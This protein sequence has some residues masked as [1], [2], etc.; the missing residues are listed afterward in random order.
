MRGRTCVHIAVAHSGGQDVNESLPFRKQ[1]QRSLR[2]TAR[3]VPD[4]CY[5]RGRGFDGVCSEP[6]TES[7]QQILAGAPEQRIRDPSQ[8]FFG[9]LAAGP[10]KLGLHS[11]GTECMLDVVPKATC[12]LTGPS[13]RRFLRKVMR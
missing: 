6:R 10:V 7:R 11:I 4:L 8:E 3:P 13:R 9:E 12:L 5:E 2:V 1:A